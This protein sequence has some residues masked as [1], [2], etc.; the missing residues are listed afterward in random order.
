MTITTIP[1]TSHAHQ[2]PLSALSARGLETA[3]GNEHSSPVLST[4]QNNQHSIFGIC[5][6]SENECITAT[7]NCSS[8]GSCVE[9]IAS[10]GCWMCLCKPSVR[11]VGDGRG[12]QTTYWAGEECQKKDVTVPFHLFFWVCELEMVANVVYDCVGVDDCFWG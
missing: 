6:T 5:H 8:H 7:N 10:S 3:F 4:Q 2:N 1:P 11:D 9:S 12:R